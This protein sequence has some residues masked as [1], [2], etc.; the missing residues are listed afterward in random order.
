MKLN[1]NNFKGLRQ[2]IDYPE[3]PKNYCHALINIDVDDPVGKMRVRDGYAHKYN[4]ALTGYPF[5]GIISAY[6]YRFDKSSET[7]LFVNDNGTLKT[8]TD[9]GA[10]VTPTLPTSAALATNFRNQY[11]GYKDHVIITTGNGATNYVLWYGYVDREIDDDTALFGNVKEKTGYILTKSQLI[12]PNGMFSN[13]YNVIYVDGYYYFS[14]ENSKW[15]EKRDT[16]FHFIER[17][18][19]STED[20]TV[21]ARDN[22]EVALATDGTYIYVAYQQTGGN[23]EISI[24]KINPNGWTQE[25]EYIPTT[26]VVDRDPVGICSDGTH[27]Y[28]LCQ[29]DD[30]DPDYIIYKLLCADMSHVADDDTDLDDD[31]LDICCDDTAS[32]GY[33]YILRTG[34]VNRRLKSDLTE[35]ESYTSFADLQHCEY[36]N[37]SD[38]LLVSSIT[39]D[40]KVYIFDAPDTDLTSN[41]TKTEIDE[42]T[43]FVHAGGTTWRCISSKYGTLE[44][45]DDDNTLYPGLIGINLLSQAAG[46][47]VIGTYFYKLSIV[48]IDGQEYTLS[49]SIQAIHTADDR[50]ST[51]RIIAHTDYL[52]DLYRVQYINI[53]RAYSTT[54][55]AEIPDTDYKFLKQVDINSTQ[56]EDDETDQELFYYD[57]IDDVLE[58]AISSTTFL[59]SSGIGDAV[60]PR[61][62]NF[63]F[64]AWVNNQL[65]AANFIHDG[66]NH[67]NRIIMSPAD[68]PD[69]IALYDYYD[70]E[71]GD[72]DV[73]KGIVDSYGRSIVFKNRKFGVY[74]DGS[75]QRSFTPGL[76]SDVAFAKNDEDI[77]FISDKGLHFFD[78]NNCINIKGPV[79]TLFDAATS[80][81]NACVFHF[82]EKNRII[83]SLRNDRAFVFNYVHKTWTYYNSYFA[84]RGHFKNYANEYIG[85]SGTSFYILLNSSYTND[86]MTVTGTG[87]QSI[88]IDYESPLLRLTNGEGMFAIPISHSHRIYKGTDVVTFTLYRYEYD[89]SGKTSIATQVITASGS[90]VAGVV[91]YF[92]D[93]EIGESF[94]IQIGGVILSGAFKYHGLTIDFISGGRWYE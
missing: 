15:I 13:V 10:P 2:D 78:G 51:L 57:H 17:R 64:M 48:D 61:Y 25:G 3:L 73:I 4:S 68:Q 47:Q 77:Y 38:E 41:S 81:A 80:Y 53:Y 31:G 20:A 76:S 23:D 39:S 56:W 40:G 5:S 50:K 29:G 7:I 21:Q 62:V 32:T 74:L 16:D 14:F 35:D 66:D 37:T 6:E 86:I 11:F 9:G 55:D 42:P 49:D 8:M 82:E 93:R 72:G 28:V 46:S 58:S 36:D 63:K 30:G 94:S 91:T 19:A 90:T 22:V 87:G 26:A 52:N 24:E 69:N 33:F 44:E 67:R 89:A 45:I 65:H 54:D 59:E 12:C 83:F 34:E 43:A 60:K 88:T 75:H 92:F 71:V 27:V 70:F 1:I 79:I 85:Y 84:F 18:I